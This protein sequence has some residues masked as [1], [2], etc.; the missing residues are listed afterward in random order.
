[1]L[2][3][4]NLTL[5]SGPGERPGLQNAKLTWSNGWVGW[6]IWC[7]MIWYGLISIISDIVW[8][9][10]SMGDG[11]ERQLQ[12]ICTHT[13]L[14]YCT[15]RQIKLHKYLKSEI[16]HGIVATCWCDFWLPR[17]PWL[18]PDSPGF[19]CSSCPISSL[20]LPIKRALSGITAI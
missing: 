10:S 15:W 19:P 12:C 16:K 20:R 6:L 1:M 2:I 18:T 17:L 3:I 13:K 11:P 8:A 7:G 4:F 9:S 5:C 14:S